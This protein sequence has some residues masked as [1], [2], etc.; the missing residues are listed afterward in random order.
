MAVT[1]TPTV[2]ERRPAAVVAIIGVLVFLGISAVA[3]GIAMVLG[4]GAAPPEDW[5]TEIPLIDNW[6]VP[7]LVLGIGFGV[8][9][10]VSAYGMLRRPAWPWLRFPE[11]L[12]RHHWSWLATVLI[13]A[14]HIAWITIELI[15]IPLSVLQ[16]VY[17]GVGV[18]LLFLPLHPAVRRYL[19]AGPA[20]AR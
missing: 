20:T 17:G 2:T 9:S 18:A 7:G 11:R 15:Y 19:T 14:G 5:L 12:T 4:V 10:L 1:V 13:G 6:V 8:G 3:G 16:A